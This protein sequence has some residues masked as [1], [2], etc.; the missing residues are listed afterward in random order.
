MLSGNAHHCLLFGVL[1]DINLA[2]TVTLHKKRCIK[3]QMKKSKTI[4][5]RGVFCRWKSHMRFFFFV[6]KLHFVMFPHQLLLFITNWLNFRWN[7]WFRI[8]KGFDKHSFLILNY[9]IW[10]I[11]TKKVSLLVFPS[12]KQYFADGGARSKPSHFLLLFSVFRSTWQVRSVSGGYQEE[13]RVAEKTQ[14]RRWKRG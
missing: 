10:S 8:L 12:F 11:R 9:F 2:R 3:R 1:I 5:N 7:A 6:K 14:Q 13:H 4:K